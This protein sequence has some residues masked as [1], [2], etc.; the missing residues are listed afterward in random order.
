MA[1]DCRRASSLRLGWCGERS[2][3]RRPDLSFRV[4]FFPFPLVFSVDENPLGIAFN[5]HLMARP[6]CG[7]RQY[8]GNRPS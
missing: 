7:A 4:L 6:A 3:P 8:V 5:I 1:D 2:G